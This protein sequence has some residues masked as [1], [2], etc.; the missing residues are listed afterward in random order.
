[1]IS[2]LRSPPP[3]RLL[4]HNC[5]RART[6]MTWTLRAPGRVHS[7]A[8]PQPRAY[9]HARLSQRLERFRGGTSFSRRDLPYLAGVHNTLVCGRYLRSAASMGQRTV[10]KEDQRNSIRIG[11]KAPRSEVDLTLTLRL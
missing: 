10:R 2:A 3:N 1:M 6:W 4:S 9:L 11:E 5:R 7:N 8:R